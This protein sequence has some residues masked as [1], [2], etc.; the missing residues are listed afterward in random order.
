MISGQ[1][2]VTISWNE[3]KVHLK[4]T[5]DAAVCLNIFLHPCELYSNTDNCYTV[6]FNLKYN[7]DTLRDPFL[8]WYKNSFNPNIPPVLVGLEEKL[9]PSLW[10]IFQISKLTD[11]AYFYSMTGGWRRKIKLYRYQ[12]YYGHF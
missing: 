10:V 11:V 5:L 4:L 9:Q 3:D 7:N 6:L 12:Y 2:S 1:E 8:S